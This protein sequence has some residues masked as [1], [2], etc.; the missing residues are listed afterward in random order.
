MLGNKRVQ[1]LE[2]KVEALETNLARAILA[3]SNLQERP[4]E[5]AKPE[6]E[7]SDKFIDRD[8]LYNYQ[9][10]KSRKGKEEDEE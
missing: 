1:E 2:K 4:I 5:L 6:P 9:Y 8:G 7:P 10:Y 3:I